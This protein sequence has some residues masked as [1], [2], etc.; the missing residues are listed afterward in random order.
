MGN[1]RNK[2]RLTHTFKSIH[3]YA[4]L[5]APKA[6]SLS[7]GE[8]LIISDAENEGLMFKRVDALNYE[9]VVR[10]IQQFYGE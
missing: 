9:D 8:S 10:Y 5:K 4:V 3:Q 7:E 2:I 6:E 1:N